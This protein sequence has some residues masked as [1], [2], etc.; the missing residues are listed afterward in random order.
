ML[1][2]L[3]MKIDGLPELKVID[4]RLGLPI[5]LIKEIEL[6]DETY[7]GEYYNISITLKDARKLLV[8]F[9]EERY[10]GFIKQLPQILE[11]IKMTSE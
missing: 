11:L 6:I 10:A 1:W 3:P 8:F 5:D 4:G 2:V 9:E 7:E